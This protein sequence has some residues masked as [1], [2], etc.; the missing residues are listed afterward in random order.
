MSQL[1][2]DVIKNTSTPIVELPF[3]GEDPIDIYPERY[4]A[5]IPS[6][7]C[8]EIA[9]RHKMEIFDDFDPGCSVLLFGSGHSFWANFA[10]SLPNIAKVSVLDYIPEAGLGLNSGID[11]YCDDILTKDITGKYDYVFSAHTVEHFNREQVLTRILPACT[12]AAD[13]AV[14]FLVPYG[15]AWSDEPSHKCLFY[16]TDELAVKAKRYKIIRDGVE[17]VLW[18]TE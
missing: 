5:D 17:L 12:A 7:D 4:M 11:F 14:V 15:I 6:A 13:K 8:W 1:W 3:R 16:E 2:I 9:H 18:F 10:Q